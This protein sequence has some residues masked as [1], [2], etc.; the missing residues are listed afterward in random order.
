MNLSTSTSR[1]TLT[2]DDPDRGRHDQ[3]QRRAD[4]RAASTA[5][6]GGVSAQNLGTSVP[7][8]IL[9]FDLSHNVATSAADADKVNTE[10]LALHAHR[11][12]GRRRQF[13]PPDGTPT[14]A[15]RGRTSTAPPRGSAASRASWRSGGVNNACAA[16]LYVDAAEVSVAVD[17][18]ASAP[19]SAGLAAAGA[20]RPPPPPRPSVAAGRQ[21]PTVE[22]DAGD[23]CSTAALTSRRSGCRRRRGAARAPSAGGRRRPAPPPAGYRC[24]TARREAA[25]RAGQRQRRV[26]RTAG[27]QG[28]AKC[29]T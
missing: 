29:G 17:W 26:P 22:L 8:R 15:T 11:C 24:T 21:P 9:N 28:A 18:S 5:R 1:A 4:V 13:A 6:V 25:P 20:R 14:A 3:R 2:G 10:L 12:R 19:G 7:P 23:Y 16:C 27:P